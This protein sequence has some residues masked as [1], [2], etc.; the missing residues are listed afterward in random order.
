MWI[1]DP[2]VTGFGATT[3]SPI[4]APADTQWATNLTGGGAHQWIIVRVI[5]LVNT[6]GFV[7]LVTLTPP[8]TSF[9]IRPPGN[10]YVKV[11]DID[12]KVSVIRLNILASGY[13][14]YEIR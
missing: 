3:E 10:R 9:N 5:F 13:S 7:E 14:N 4:R 11:G 2:T 1:L 6:N 8:F 12:A